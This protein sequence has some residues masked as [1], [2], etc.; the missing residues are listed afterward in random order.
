MKL[1]KDELVAH[2]DCVVHKYGQELLVRGG[3]GGSGTVDC[4]KAD[5]WRPLRRM[6][7]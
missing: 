7:R 1:R 5:T 6:L 2:S 3:E 4:L